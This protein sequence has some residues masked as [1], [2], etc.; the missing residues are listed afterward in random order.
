MSDVGPEPDE[1]GE[2]ACYANLVCAEC[3]AVLDEHHPASCRAG[4][5]GVSE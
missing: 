1:G 5:E 4:P 2:A 3:G